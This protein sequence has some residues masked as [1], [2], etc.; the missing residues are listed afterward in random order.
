MDNERTLAGK[1]DVLAT[2]LNERTRRLWAGTE[3]VAY[4]R[5]GI[6]AVMRVTGLSRNTVVRG[7]REAAETHPVDVARIRAR[8]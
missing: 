3:A 1:Y 2:A 8:G 7:I 5:G 4:G 6:A